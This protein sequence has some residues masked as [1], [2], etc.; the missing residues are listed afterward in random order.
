[1]NSV[2]GWKIF[3]H[4]YSQSTLNKF[5]VIEQCKPFVA[6]VFLVHSHMPHTDTAHNLPAN[7]AFSNNKTQYRAKILIMSHFLQ[8]LLIYKKKMETITQFV[9]HR[10]F[11]YILHG[12]NRHYKTA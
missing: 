9:S 11:F 1:M 5:M 10:L 3:A 2:S 8:L 6:F 7:T 12:I 4:L